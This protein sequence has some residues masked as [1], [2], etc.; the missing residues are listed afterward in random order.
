MTDLDRLY[1]ALP[2]K[3]C[4]PS[5][6]TAIDASLAGAASVLDG[7]SVENVLIASPADPPRRF[8]ADVIFVDSVEHL[9]EAK[10]SHSSAIAVRLSGLT[11]PLLQSFQ[12]LEK[13]EP[14]IVVGQGRSRFLVHIRRK[15]PKSTARVYLDPRVGVEGLIEFVRTAGLR[16]VALRWFDDLPA[17]APGEDLDLLVHGDDQALLR[18]WLESRPGTIPIDLYSHD[19]RSPGDFLRTRYFPPRLA[20]DILAHAQ[21]HPSGML[22]PARRDYF[23]SL[24]FHAIYHKGESSGMPLESQPAVRVASTDHRSDRKHDYVDVLED[25]ARR[26]GDEG[27]LPHRTMSLDSGLSLIK[28]LGDAPSLDSAYMLARGNQWLADRLVSER[29]ESSADDP[30]VWTAFFIRERALDV[31]DESEIMETI[32]PDRS[33]FLVIFW[34]RLTPE[35][36]SRANSRVRGGNWG[37]GPFAISGGPPALLALVCDFSPEV[38]PGALVENE[39]FQR[40]KEKLRRLVRSR[41]ESSFNAAH[42]ADSRLMSIEYLEVL[43]PDNRRAALSALERL[44]Q[45]VKGTQDESVIR[46]LSINSRSITDLVRVGPDLLVRKR[47]FPWAMG[48]YSAEVAALEDLGS[49]GLAPRKQSHDS[50]TIFIEYH[51]QRKSVFSRPLRRRDLVEMLEVVRGAHRTGWRLRDVHPGNFIRDHRSGKLLAIDLEDAVRAEPIAKGPEV[52]GADAV[53]GFGALQRYGVPVCERHL[54]SGIFGWMLCRVYGRLMA[55]VRAWRDRILGR[56]SR[57]RVGV[58]RRMKRLWL[59]VRLSSQVALRGVRGTQG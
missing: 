53:S 15:A 18:A 11:D 39:R 2:S 14:G 5:G 9:G 4:H 33:R 45:Q 49:C 24:L 30:V 36:A 29:S 42:S 22:V 46:R 56:A 7:L 55:H 28:D 47:Y 26:I 40:R 25:L 3:R 41:S 51:P 6:L 38:R 58:R 44:R 16:V 54:E 48:A 13:F 50:C 21:A 8:A 32:A 10:L 1:A 52:F 59:R 43:N 57:I 37:P 27:L 12:D 23:R 17:L 20:E 19:G 35:E 31:L 34:H